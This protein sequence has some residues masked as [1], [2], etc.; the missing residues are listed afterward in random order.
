M[1]SKMKVLR[2][3]KVELLDSY[4]LDRMHFNFAKKYLFLSKSYIVIILSNDC[5]SCVYD[6]G[7]LRSTHTI[8][9]TNVPRVTTMIILPVSNC[10]MNLL[11][12]C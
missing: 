6:L 5:N 11:R 10:S 1:T 12:N 7:Y 4:V 2:S 9:S 8:V 3:D